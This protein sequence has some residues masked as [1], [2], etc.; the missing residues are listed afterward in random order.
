[1]DSF[2]YYGDPTTVTYTYGVVNSTTVTN[3]VTTSYSYT[4]GFSGTLFG[5][6]IGNSVTFT[7]SSTKSNKTQSTDTSMLSLTM[8]TTAYSGPN[9]LNVY[10]DTVYKTF[11]FSFY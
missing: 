9:T 2:S 8:P 5:L 7:D 6:K 10:E 1:L 11:M 3:S 4:E